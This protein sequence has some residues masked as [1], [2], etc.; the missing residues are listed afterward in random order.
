MDMNDTPPTAE[1]LLRRIQEL[2]ARHALIKQKISRRLPIEVTNLTENQYLNILQSMGQSVFIYDLNHR[3]IFWNRRAEHIYGYTAS[4][5]IGR[6]PTELLAEPKDAVFSEMILERT[7]NGESWSGE[8][9]ITNK[10]GESFVVIC[11]N[12]PFR[13]ETGRLV[14]AMC[15]STDSRPYQAT[16]QQPQETSVVS[17]ISNWAL[18]VKMKM[19]T[20][21]DSDN[22]LESE[23]SSRS[24]P[25]GHIG[26]SPF[27]V[28]FSSDTDEQYFTR[29][30][31]IKT[32]ENTR[33]YLS[34]NAEVKEMV[35]F[36]TR[37]GMRSTA[38]A[39]LDYQIS[40]EASGPM[41]S[42]SLHVSR[43]DDEILS[44]DLITKQQIGQGSCGT[45]YHGLWHGSDVAIKV[46][47]YQELSDDLMVSFRQEV[48]LMKRLRHPNILLFM[49]AVTSPH[50]LCIVTEFLPR[51]SLFRILQRNA[52][53][54]DRK[55]R[56]QMAIDI[57]RGMNYLHHCNPPIV[58]RDLKS[59]NL[60]VDKN[61]TVKVGDFGLS[62]IKHQTYLNTKSGKG[63]PQWMAP[64]IIRN[65]QAD[66]KSD[67]YSYGVV[68]WEILTDKIPWDDL[69]PMQVI[70]AVGFMN[71]RLEIPKDMDP[72]WATLI[73][74]SWCSDQQSRPTFQ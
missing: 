30:L 27:G 20:G 53:R 40:T 13:D 25:R 21:G 35:P 7:V 14:G 62:R 61:W 42:S 18:K 73:E 36:D 44:E 17:K 50:Q 19:K 3:I 31:I 65:E 58:H 71:R 33:K 49:G 9:P 16:Q 22:I 26:R 47:A 56:L 24:T 57:A 69:N 64:E 10:S 8:F 48:S 74:S 67:V 29:N 32:S 55:R 1:E 59:S 28:F 12:T 4:E 46:F 45:V 6:T 38:P 11:A 51:G 39:K 63:T 66:E 52:D 5:V 15:M 70:A 41:R 34:S 72:L 37:F 2:E 54:L 68:L 43:M 23:G 60:L